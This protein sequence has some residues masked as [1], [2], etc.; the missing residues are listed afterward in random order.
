MKNRTR[1]L[2]A[3]LGLA[4]A[5]VGF[6]LWAGA[7]SWNAETA[8]IVE[9]LKKKT[10]RGEAKTVSFKDFDNLPAPVARYF[11]FV[12]K[13][14]SPIIKAARIQHAGE[15]NLNGAWIP[16]ES[17]QHF[18]GKPPAFVWDA[19]M[20]MNVLMSVRVRDA[21]LEGNG[22][23]TAKIY[24]LFPVMTVG[25]DE[26]L[27]AGALQRFLAEAVWLPTALLPDENLKWTAID[28]KR[29]TATLTDAGVTVSLDF[30]FNEK[31]EIIGVFT[32]ARFREMNGEYKPFPWAGR[33]WN[34]EERNGM[35]I[36]TAGEVEWQMPDGVQPYWRG[37]VT[38]IEY[39]FA[40]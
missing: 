21:Y 10:V 37:C 34:Y 11:R 13:D 1:F 20:Q 16:F 33:F 27:A 32:P 12:L 2:L 14:A 9:K 40:E 6:A 35:K 36:P 28:D 38:Q 7:V 4:S 23:M 26:K 3:G 17:E 5:G 29:A 19:K 24:S 31:G 30:E 18:K 15:F 8:R 22:S 25:Q 39:E